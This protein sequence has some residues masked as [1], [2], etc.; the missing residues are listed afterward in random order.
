VASEDRGRIHARV[1]A[2]LLFPMSKKR[3]AWPVAEG[4]S[5]DV[6]GGLWPLDSARAGIG[7]FLALRLAS[8]FHLF[9]RVVQG[10]RSKIGGT[11]SYGRYAARRRP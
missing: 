2:G 5:S 4:P 7:G 1:D 10:M 9:L 8:R 11:R 3:R 6:V